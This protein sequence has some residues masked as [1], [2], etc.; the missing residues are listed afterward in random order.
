MKYIYA[1]IFLLLPIPGNSQNTSEEELK[2]IRIKYIKQAQ[3]D[4]QN[5]KYN[6]L[7]KNSSAFIS[8]YPE[9]PN[10]YHYSAIVFYYLDQF[11]N[12]IDNFT[13]V[14]EINPKSGV[15]HANRGGVYATLG[16]DSLALADFKEALSFNSKNSTAYNNRSTVYINNQQFDNALDDLRN[17]IIGNKPEVDN[18]NNMA[19][20]YWYKKDLDSALY[21]TNRA[22]DIDAQYIYCLDMKVDILYKKGEQTELFNTCRKLIDVATN[23]I[24]NSIYLNFSYRSRG[25]AYEIL[26]NKEKAEEDYLKASQLLTKLIAQFPKSYIFLYNRGNMYMK[27][28]KIEKANDD[29]FR[30][31]EINPHYS[32]FLLK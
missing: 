8:K 13:K 25:K 4:L 22:L 2:Q 18:F 6:D 14:L 23:N 24:E 30:A 28:G 20:V 32:E 10:A 5:K 17:A 29:Y 27:L 15:T 21:F 26:G 7:I 3:A 16:Y 19:S 31:K 12:S 9:I 11:Q 1:I